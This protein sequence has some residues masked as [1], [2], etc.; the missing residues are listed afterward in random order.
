MDC[1]RWRGMMEG[2]VIGKKWKQGNPC[3][4]LYTR[5]FLLFIQGPGIRSLGE[6]NKSAVLLAGLGEQNL[7][8]DNTRHL[9]DLDP[10]S[11]S[12]TFS[13]QWSSS[14][15]LSRWRHCLVPRLWF[16]GYTSGE[17]KISRS[18]WHWR[19]QWIWSHLDTVGMEKK[20]SLTTLPH[21][22][23]LIHDA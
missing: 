22:R 18:R 8:Q 13:R 9:L 5:K 19:V 10:C 15:L 21:S 3:S 2:N 7:I 1:M 16:G 17:Q 20:A 6:T 4:F 11:S 14:W 12:V 23:T